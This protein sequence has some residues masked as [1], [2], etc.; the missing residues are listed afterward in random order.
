MLSVMTGAALRSTICASA[1]EV[2]ASRNASAVTC[3]GL[4]EPAHRQADVGVDHARAGG[5]VDLDHLRLVALHRHLDL[6]GAGD[7][8][9]Q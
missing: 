8:V 4:G 1:E 2:T 5:H 3:H 6:V 7:E 9:E